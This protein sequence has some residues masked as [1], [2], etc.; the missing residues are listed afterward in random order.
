MMG[1][2]TP[3]IADDVVEVREF[4]SEPGTVWEVWTDAGL[5]SSGG[6]RM[7]SLPQRSR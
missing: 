4:E 7:A 5:I 2:M 3:A 1:L 6:D